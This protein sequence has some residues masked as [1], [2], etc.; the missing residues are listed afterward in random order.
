M[1]K[2]MREVVK[3]VFHQAAAE[4]DEGMFAVGP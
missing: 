1:E 4:S 3:R 2:L